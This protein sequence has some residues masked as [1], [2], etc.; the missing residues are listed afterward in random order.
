MIND[1]VIANT[2]QFVD[3]LKKSLSEANIKA[4][5]AVVTI[6]SFINNQKRVDINSVED[7]DD[8]ELVAFE[9]AKYLPINIDEY[10]ISHN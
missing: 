1:G 4:K 10:S 2:K 8:N 5:D 9:L 3:F 7:A 6:D